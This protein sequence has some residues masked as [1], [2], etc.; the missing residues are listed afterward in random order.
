MGMLIDAFNATWY[1]WVLVIL[2]SIIKI[3][4]PQIKRIFR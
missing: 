1:L 4:L 2:V 3:F